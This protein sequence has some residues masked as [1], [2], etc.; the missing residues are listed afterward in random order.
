M[1]NYIIIFFALISLTTLSSLKSAN[2]NT[3][4]NFQDKKSAHIEFET[5]RHDFGVITVGGNGSFSFKFKNTGVEPLIIQGVRSSCGCTIAKK[6]NAPILPGAS[7]IISVRYDTRRIGVF[8]KT[9]TVTTNAD[10]ISTVLVIRGEVKAKPKEEAP[11]K[12]ESKGF[13]P[14]SK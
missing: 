2:Y 14:T 3:E 6:P 9:I 7:D 1:K 12:P 13:T 8:H 5:T 4:L 11:V 10:N